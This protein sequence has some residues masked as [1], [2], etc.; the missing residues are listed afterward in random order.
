M[1]RFG[2][3]IPELVNRVTILLQAD[4]ARELQDTFRSGFEKKLRPEF[5]QYFAVLLAGKTGSSP[6][7][8]GVPKTA[9]GSAD[10]EREIERHDDEFFMPGVFGRHSVMKQAPAQLAAAEAFHPA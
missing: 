2:R 1:G 4:T 5:K 10:M 8:L 7:Q 9:P 6:P 3:N